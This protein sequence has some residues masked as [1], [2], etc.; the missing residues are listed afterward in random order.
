MGARRRGR[1]LAMQA[2]YQIEVTGGFDPQMVAA[3]W[4]DVRVSDEA[5]R[6]AAC[7]VSGVRERKAEIDRLIAQAAEHWRLDR[8]SP[9]DLSIL[10]VGTYE[11][12]TS[13]VPM[14]AVIINE[15][16]EIAKRFGT[17]DSPQFVNK[18]LDRLDSILGVKEAG[19]E[20]TVNTKVRQSNG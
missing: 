7:L 10:R 3:T 18:V 8:M 5:R 16:I 12:L 11:L 19:R 1:E 6:F 13:E 20:N 2:L 14:T 17:Q 4:E 9:V 15:A